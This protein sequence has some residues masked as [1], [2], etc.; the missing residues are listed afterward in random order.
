MKIADET[1][2]RDTLADFAKAFELFDFISSKQGEAPLSLVR[3]E[4]RQSA[5]KD[6]GL[7]FTGS[8]K[9]HPG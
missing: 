4:R 2:A 5:I 1:T 6:V 8:L 7:A 9:S 3:Q